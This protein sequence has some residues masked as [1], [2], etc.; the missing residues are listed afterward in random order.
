MAKQSH[1]SAERVTDEWLV[2]RCQEGS[3]K[4]LNLL[5]HRWQPK[6]AA[7]AF[8]LTGDVDATSDILQDSLLGI[9]HGLQNLRDPAKFPS[10]ALTIVSHKCRDWIRRRAKERTLPNLVKNDPATIPDT[11]GESPS[12]R[13]QEALS[14]LSLN[15]RELLRL[16]YY[17]GLTLHEISTI[18]KIPPGTVK[19]RLF[20]AREHL[21]QHLETNP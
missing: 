7:R 5:L 20:A 9:A 4:A 14:L 10:W 6:L 17:E 15:D 18:E 13:V 1:R 21:R 8:R 11:A 3:A 2:L 12:E 19:S 16:H